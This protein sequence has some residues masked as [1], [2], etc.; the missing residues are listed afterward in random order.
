MALDELLHYDDEP[1]QPKPG[2]RIRP[3]RIVGT[4]IGCVLVSLLILFGLHAAGYSAP[5]LLVLTAL[6][7]AVTLYVLVRD[8]G[9]RPLPGT[10]TKGPAPSRWPASDDDGLLNAVRHWELRLDW[11]GRDGNRF[12]S[13]TQ[14]GIVEIIDERLRVRHGVDRRTDPA[15]AREL[16]GPRLYAFVTEPVNRRMNGQELA[17]LASEMEDL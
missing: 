13:A 6:L 12:A 3:A 14:P 7:A 1:V 4:V 15:R 2:P 11:T 9:A 10:L 5:F 8:V 17:V 16:L